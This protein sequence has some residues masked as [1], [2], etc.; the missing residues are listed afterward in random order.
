MKSTSYL[1][2]SLSLLLLAACT[3]WPPKKKSRK[4]RSMSEPVTGDLAD[5][6]APYHRRYVVV[7]RAHRDIDTLRDWMGD[8]SDEVREAVKGWYRDRHA[9]DPDVDK[10][11]ELAEL[12][13]APRRRAMKRLETANE[14]YRPPWLGIPTGEDGR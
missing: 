1:T 8:P 6:V 12:L 5:E 7:Y 4:V 13:E 3:G 11:L 10:V 9:S 2:L 14:D